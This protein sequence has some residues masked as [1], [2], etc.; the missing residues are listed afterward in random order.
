MPSP[1]V[2][3]SENWHG[4]TG[5][6]LSVIVPVY[7]DWDKV[8]HCI[9]SILNQKQPP[10]FEVIV[11]DDGSTHEA[12]RFPEV[13]NLTLVRENHMGVSHARNR[14]I[15]VAR[16]ELLLFVDSDCVLKPNCLCEL[17]RTFRERPQQLAFQLHIV[18]EN[19]TMVGRAEWLNLHAIQSVLTDH[20][21][22]I[23][24]LNTAGFAVV[25]SFV[26]S[27]G[28]RFEPRAIRAQDTYLLSELIRKGHL[29]YLATNCVVDHCVGLG[30]T[31]YIYK[32]FRTAF[33]TQRTYTLIQ[34]NGVRVHATAEQR[35]RI[36]KAMIAN[37]NGRQFGLSAF[38]VAICRYAS[39]KMG[40]IIARRLRCGQGRMAR[41]F[42]FA[43]GVT[44]G[45]HD[46]NLP[47]LDNPAQCPARERQANDHRQ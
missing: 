31:E 36:F 44:N 12:P 37:A 19:S 18:G 14:G 11:V 20:D 35:L 27:T 21:G 15:E 41:G 17:E 39:G 47:S 25:R 3:A 13:S 45:L 33:A 2:A 5:P 29:P 28:L 26:L 38:L 10:S 24:W 9:S 32:S 34:S 6:F 42:D 23:R 22:C 4:K 8:T 46:G 43:R 40:L 16:G 7:N 1:R 30:I